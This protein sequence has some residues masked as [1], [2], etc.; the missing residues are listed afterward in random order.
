MAI[1]VKFHSNSFN[2]IVVKHISPFPLEDDDF[3]DFADFSTGPA[4]ESSAENVQ[5]NGYAWSSA[6]QDH[7]TSAPVSTKPITSSGIEDE[8]NASHRSYSY[9]CIEDLLDEIDLK[10]TAT[11]SSVYDDSLLISEEPLLLQDFFASM[12]IASHISKQIRYVTQIE[13]EMLNT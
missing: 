2:Y 3:E 13:V 4:N 5:M 11:K 10:A 12:S 9:V 7:V 8:S 6:G 1:G